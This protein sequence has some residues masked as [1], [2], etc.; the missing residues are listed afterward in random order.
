MPKARKTDMD[1]ASVLLTLFFGGFGVVYGAYEL[2]LGHHPV[3]TV[4]S[5]AFGVACIV[6]AIVLLIQRWPAEPTA[7]LDQQ[8]IQPIE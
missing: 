7:Q 4:F 8:H 2:S 5:Y 6:A 3:L 1:I